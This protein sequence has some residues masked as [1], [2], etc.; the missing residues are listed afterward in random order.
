MRRIVSKHASLVRVRVR[1][2]RLAG[3]A[4]PHSRPDGSGA[5]QDSRRGAQSS[6]LVSPRMRVSSS[7]GSRSRAPISTSRWPPLAFAHVHSSHG[8]RSRA[9]AALEVAAPPSA[10]VCSSP[11]SRSPRPLEHL[12]VAAL[13]R[14]RASPR[15]TGSRSRAPPNTSGGR[16]T[17][18]TRRPLVPGS[19]FARISD[20]SRWPPRAATRTSRPRAVVLARPSAPGAPFAAHM[21]PVPSSRSRAPFSTEVATLRSVRARPLVHGKILRTNAFNSSGSP[22]RSCSAEELV[23]SR[24]RRRRR[25]R[26]QVSALGGKPTIQPSSS[27][28]FRPVAS[29]ASRIPCSRR[30][31][32]RGPRS[33]AGVFQ[34]ARR[35]HR[36]EGPGTHRACASRSAF[37]ARSLDAARGSATIACCAACSARRCAAGRSEICDSKCRFLGRYENRTASPHQSA[38]G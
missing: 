21:R 13:R 33:R 3:S 8:Q 17:P 25:E 38:G 5:I 34:Q 2:V 15:S 20:T 11:G 7:T 30:E 14:V 22:R 36:R 37:A 16:P 28:I 9:P 29:T 1:K 12:E 18:P 6:T 4:G 32:P 23:D 31:A 26:A 24:P 19:R 27:F 35:R 10:H